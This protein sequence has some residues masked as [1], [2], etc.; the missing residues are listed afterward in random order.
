MNINKTKKREE[1]NSKQKN[2]NNKKKLKRTNNKKVTYQN[3]QNKDIQ[4]TKTQITYTKMTLKNNN[5]NLKK[6]EE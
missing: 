5:I 1:N 2:N 6:E 3:Y 4:Q